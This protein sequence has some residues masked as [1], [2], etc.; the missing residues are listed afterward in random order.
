MKLRSNK[1]HTTNTTSLMA[2]K[3][4]NAI[5]ITVLYM[6]LFVATLPLYTYWWYDSLMHFVVPMAMTWTGIEIDVISN[7]KAVFIVFLIMIHW[8]VFEYVF[9][10]MFRTGYKD[11]L[12]DLSLGAIGT[13]V[14]L[15]AREA[16]NS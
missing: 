10:S 6:A 7:A 5:S 2:N 8:E 9:G 3:R 4:N 13:G 14:F 15:V 1:P 11:T 16:H 12:I